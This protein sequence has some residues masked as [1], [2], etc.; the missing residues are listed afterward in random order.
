MGAALEADGRYRDA[1]DVV[2]LK[3]M[4]PSLLRDATAHAHAANTAEAWMTLAEVYS[5]VRTRHLCGSW[6]APGGAEAGR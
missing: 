3:K 2:G 5:S 4:L 1:V 6:Q